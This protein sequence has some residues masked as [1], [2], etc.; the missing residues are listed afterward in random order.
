MTLIPLK[1]PPQGF[2]GLGWAAGAARRWRRKSARP[3]N[4]H[5]TCSPACRSK[6]AASGMGTLTKKRGAWPL[7]RI[8]CTRKTYSAVEG[9]GDFED[10]VDFACTSLC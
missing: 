9:L 2:C 5:C 4:C 3:S 8:A 1:N 7:E 6:A 10:F